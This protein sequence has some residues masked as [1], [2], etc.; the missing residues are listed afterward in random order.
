[1]G[2]RRAP[3]EGGQSEVNASTSVVAA[4][5]STYAVPISRDERDHELRAALFGIEASAVGLCD[6]RDEATAHQIDSLARGL[7]AEARRV[8]AL[9]EGRVDNP[10]TFDLADAIAPVL[11]CARASGLEIVSMLPGGIVVHGGPDRTAQVVVAL[12]DN[13]RQHAPGSPVDVRATARG[14]VAELYV[15]DR[16][17]GIGARVPER[18][19]GRGVR[20]DES[21]GSGLGLF[22]ARRVMAGQGGSID[23]HPRPGGGA[24]FVL[25]FR[26]FTGR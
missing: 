26:R 9:V 6:F 4:A 25:R 18:V 20:G 16:G 19:F 12:L 22:I 1:M 13:A 17:P 2:A 24:S 10:T 11:A 7:A 5:P 21:S 15:Q 8:R 3:T 23:V 14:D